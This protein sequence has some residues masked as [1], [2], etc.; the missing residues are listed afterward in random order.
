[1]AEATAAFEAEADIASF[2]P[3]D[4]VISIRRRMQKVRKE[5]RD[6]VSQERP[7]TNTSCASSQASRPSRMRP[8]ASAPHLQAGSSPVA[9]EPAYGGLAA[10][11]LR[12]VP[13]PSKDAPSLADWDLGRASSAGSKD[14]LGGRRRLKVER[15]HKNLIRREVWKQ[16]FDYLFRQMQEGLETEIVNDRNQRLANGN[17]AV[18]PEPE[19]GPAEDNSRDPE[20]P[21][22][23]GLEDPL[24][25][26]EA[27]GH[28]SRAGLEGGEQD[29]DSVSAGSGA[30]YREV[31]SISIESQGLPLLS[32]V[33]CLEDDE[34]DV[35]AACGDTQLAQV[36]LP[37]NMAQAGWRMTGPAR[38]QPRAVTASSKGPKAA[39]KLGGAKAKPSGATGKGVRGLLHSSTSLPLLQPAPD[40][41]GVRDDYYEGDE[42][43]MHEDILH[44]SNPQLF[45]LRAGHGKPFPLLKLAEMSLAVGKHK[46]LGRA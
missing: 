38:F 44:A 3:G 32:P 26:A 29:A 21:H 23:E 35:L 28:E 14:I 43:F 10:S 45:P 4:S 11:P 19:P 20:A 12:D 8:T 2:R 1:M 46:R 15:F 30:G 36:K 22:A 42:L 39:A 41:L 31:S 5:H 6:I 34:F 18:P 37:P 13:V 40:L 25:A 17:V 33:K 27:G 9:P 7:W 16:K 24:E